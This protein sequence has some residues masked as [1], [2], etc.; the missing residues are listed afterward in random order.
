MEDKVFGTLSFRFG[1]TKNEQIKF[2]GK[3]YD[4]RIRTSSLKDELPTEVQQNS[5]L[6]F[7]VEQDSICEKAK[8]LVY[9]FIEVRKEQIFEQLGVRYIAN[10]ATLLTPYEVLFFKNGKYAIL[11]QTKWSEDDMCILCDGI[12]LKVDEGYILEFEY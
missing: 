6:S 2:C 11:F 8:E 10:L 12:N 7:E 9:N 3:L 4:V 1:W 5:Y